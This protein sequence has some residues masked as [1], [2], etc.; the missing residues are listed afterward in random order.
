MPAQIRYFPSQEDIK[1]IKHSITCF[2][3]NQNS[4]YRDKLLL[5]IR[6]VLDKYGIS[7]YNFDTFSVHR[8]VEPGLSFIQGKRRAE[9]RLCPACGSDIYRIDSPVRILSIREGFED[10]VTYGCR[11]GEIFYRV[12]KKQ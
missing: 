7:T 4:L 11:C 6:S 1:I 3:S 8:T 5:D 10:R 12:E 9:G 2:L